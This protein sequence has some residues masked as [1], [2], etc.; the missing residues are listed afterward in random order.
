M[1]KCCF[2]EPTS[3]NRV[4]QCIVRSKVDRFDQEH[5]W[6]RV[7]K[8]S[9]WPVTC[10]DCRTISSANVHSHP[11]KCANCN[12]ENVVELQDCLAADDSGG[13]DTILQNFN[14]KLSDGHYKCPR[15]E[16]FELVV[17]RPQDLFR[18][19]QGRCPIADFRYDAF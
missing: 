2:W 3:A 10:G 18:L 5:E 19:I 7:Q 16:K 1:P 11:L 13:A 17:R 6:E 15:C 4:V 14:R 9:D 12:S 8:P